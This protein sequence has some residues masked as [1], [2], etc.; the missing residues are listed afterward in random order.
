MF[1]V[2]PRR[3]K[4]VEILWSSKKSNERFRSEMSDPDA[5][6]RFRFAYMNRISH[7]QS[8]SENAN[9]NFFLSELEG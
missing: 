7:C 4:V 9:T 8:Q 3:E 1:D 6:V 2:N 5:L